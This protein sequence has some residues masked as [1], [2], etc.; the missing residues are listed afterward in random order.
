MTVFFIF[1]LI[2]EKVN[3]NQIDQQ[4]IG[5]Q[6]QIKN[7]EEENAELSGLI[8]EW[9]N[10]DLL[11]RQA[12]LKLGLKKVGENTVI[13]VGHNDSSA[14]PTIQ[15]NSKIVAN[16]VRDGQSS[17]QLNPVKWWDYFFHKNQ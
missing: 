14:T 10:G 1:E 13:I 4:I 5:L 8:D 6:N 12:R 15:E 2:R 17:R 9:Q 11:E 7:Y 16:V 3:G